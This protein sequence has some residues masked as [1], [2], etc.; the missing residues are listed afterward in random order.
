MIT[1]LVL[2]AAWPRIPRDTAEWILLLV[3]GPPLYLAGEAFV[4]RLLGPERKYSGVQRLFVALGI[5]I[6]CVG[7]L[8]AWA[9]WNNR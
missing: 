5:I 8:L 3:F 2:F 1:G 4:G 6:L 7:G 9:A